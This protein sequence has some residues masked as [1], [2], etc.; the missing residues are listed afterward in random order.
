[1]DK[2]EA[3]VE[4]DVDAVRHGRESPCPL[5]EARPALRVALAADRSRAEQRPIWIEEVTSAQALAG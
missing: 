1:L 2:P 3:L 4:A 5:A